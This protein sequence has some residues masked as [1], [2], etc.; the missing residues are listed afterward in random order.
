MNRCKILR[1]LY[2]CTTDEDSSEWKSHTGN[3]N[4]ISQNLRL[5]GQKIPK[6]SS[7]TSHREGLKTRAS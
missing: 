3:A 1:F 4:F 7:M 6:M 5:T 2:C